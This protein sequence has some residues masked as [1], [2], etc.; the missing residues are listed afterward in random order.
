MRILYCDT[1][2]GGLDAK[3]HALIQ[4]AGILVEN[5]K[6][7]DSFDLEMSPYKDQTVT[8]EALAINGYAPTDIV[9]LPEP[10][11]QFKKLYSFLDKYSNEKMFIAGYNI[12]FDIDFIIEFFN[13][14]NAKKVFFNMFYLPGIDVM[15]LALFKLLKNRSMMENFKQGTVAKELGIDF[16]ETELHDA[17]NDIKLTREIM[18]RISK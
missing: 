2:T 18:R 12:Q 15:Q 10:A 11:E 14:N 16:K 3:K 4:I 17:M 1:E 13:R 5:G 8:P 9:G 6:E 7:I